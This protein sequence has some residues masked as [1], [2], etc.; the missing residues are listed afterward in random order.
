MF[1]PIGPG[2][3]VSKDWE[4][5]DANACGMLEDVWNEF[6]ADAGTAAEEVQA[7]LAETN[8]THTMKVFSSDLE[9]QAALAEA[10]R[11]Q[12]AFQEELQK[13]RQKLQKRSKVKS[14]PVELGRL[15]EDEATAQALKLDREAAMAE[16]REFLA[17][18]ADSDKWEE[19]LKGWEAM[20]EDIAEVSN[21]DFEAKEKASVWASAAK[22]EDVNHDEQLALLEEAA[23]RVA[24]FDEELQKQRQQMKKRRKVLQKQGGP[25]Q[26]PDP[27]DAC[28]TM[29]DQEVLTKLTREQAEAQAQCQAMAAG[30]G[31]LDA[32]EQLGSAWAQMQILGKRLM[33]TTLHN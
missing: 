2:G 20:K 21:Q 22:M 18:G 1:L 31:M 23:R 15:L 24:V 14:A 8:A 25:E 7:A 19:L 6:R 12:A 33:P 28:R 16:C 10:A 4:E 30:N 13:Q 27:L 9:R 17:S 26:V 5:L 29:A 3:L 32:W 11:R